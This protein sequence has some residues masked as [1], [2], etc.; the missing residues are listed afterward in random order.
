LCKPPY[1]WLSSWA[2][3]HE[4]AFEILSQIQK[5]Q[6][7]SHIHFSGRSPNGTRPIEDMIFLKTK[8]KVRLEKIIAAGLKDM[9]GIS[10]LQKK[11]GN[12][13]HKISKLMKK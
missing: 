10:Y 13:K 5:G 7:I 11:K 8:A 9:L 6:F 4:N 3:D 12:A 2:G 1:N